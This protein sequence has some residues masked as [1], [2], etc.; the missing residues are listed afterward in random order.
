MDKANRLK[1]QLNSTYGKGNQ[2]PGN[3]FQMDLLTVVARLID[4]R[5]AKSNSDL[6]INRLVTYDLPRM[7]GYLTEPVK[8][9]SGLFD[10]E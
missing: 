6:V 1:L 5:E 9:W 2:F 4:L 7:E 8:K 3:T 10:E